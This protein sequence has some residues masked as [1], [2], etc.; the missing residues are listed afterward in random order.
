MDYISVLSV[1]Q[2]VNLSANN[3]SSDLM[4][5]SDWSFQW[6]IEFN[7]DPK[8]IYGI[9][10][11]NSSSCGVAHCGRVLFLF[12]KSFLVVLTGFLF[13]RGE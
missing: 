2:G 7:P 4:K 5:M 6:K 9:F 11:T 13:W 10:D 8:I 12:F 1:V 3:L